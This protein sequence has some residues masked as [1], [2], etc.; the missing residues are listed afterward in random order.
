M[1]K[2]E[3]KIWKTYPEFSFIQAS[4][5]GQIRTIDRTVTRNDG[6]KQFVKGRILK[7]RRTQKGYME[8][9]TNSNGKKLYL[10]VHRVVASCFIPNPDNL[11][12]INH[13]DCNPLNNRVENLE[14]CTHKQNVTYREK[15]GT[16]ARE[17]TRSLRKPL[18]AIRLKTL[19]VLRFESRTEAGR[20]LGVS[21]QNISA[22]LKGKQR[23]SGGYWFTNVDEDAVKNIKDKFGDEVA[24]E[25]EQLMSKK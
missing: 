5:L 18:F 22:V 14:W 7:Q 6:K 3:N 9:Q 10:K 25:I 20:A 21:Y 17:F 19:G 16:P 4:N 2:S 12:E 1:N 11:P 15:H 8:V 23:T 13:E 24:C